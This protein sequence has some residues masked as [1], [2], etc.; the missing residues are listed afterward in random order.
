MFAFLLSDEAWL[1]ATNALLGIVT[2][3]AV[4]AIGGAVFHDVLAKIR[5]RR[6]HF[7]YDSHSM[8]VPDLGFT[9]ADGGE[10]IGE[11][12]PEKK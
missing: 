3:I 2:A 10:P 6:Q 4:I 5:Q 7:V 12:H 9:M 8:H 1:N 11:D